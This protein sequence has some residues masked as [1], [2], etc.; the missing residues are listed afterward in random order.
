LHI[1]IDNEAARLQNLKDEP[2]QG[3]DLPEKEKRK[4]AVVLGSLLK[5][6][7]TQAQ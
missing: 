3:V 7:A 2:G 4:C 6:A 1:E 5:H